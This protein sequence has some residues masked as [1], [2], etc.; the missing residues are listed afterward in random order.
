MWKSFAVMR[1][2]LLTDMFIT[3]LIIIE[4]TYM[5]NEAY[6]YIFLFL[7]HLRVKRNNRIRNAHA[8]S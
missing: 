3:T 7:I 6:T 5:P 1:S 4:W 2:L 8:S